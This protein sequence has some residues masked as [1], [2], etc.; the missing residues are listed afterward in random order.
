MKEPDKDGRTNAADMLWEYQRRKQSGN[1]QRLASSVGRESL[2]R[3]ID[4]KLETWSSKSLS[5]LAMIL[6]I[7][8]CDITLY[9]ENTCVR[10]Q[11]ESHFLEPF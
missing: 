1:S 8:Q 7:G 6:L 2:E 3:R 9:G 10:K 11:C 5:Q 4:S